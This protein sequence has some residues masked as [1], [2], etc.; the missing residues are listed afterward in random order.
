MNEM[1]GYEKYFLIVASA[2]IFAVGAIAAEKN[3]KYVAV[4]NAEE[5]TDEEIYLI[6]DKESGTAMS[7]KVNPT[8][9]SFKPA[10]MRGKI[11][12]ARVE[13][14]RFGTIYELT[15]S[16]GLMKCEKVNSTTYIWK[17]SNFDNG[18]GETSNDSKLTWDGSTLNASASG[19]R[20]YQQITKDGR[21]LLYSSNDTSYQ[22]RFY[23]SNASN[24][25]WHI[26]KKNSPSS[27]ETPSTTYLYKQ[28]EIGKPELPRLWIGD[29]EVCNGET[30]VIKNNCA[31]TIYVEDADKI[32]VNGEKVA[33]GNEATLPA[34]SGKYEVYGKNSEGESESFVYN[35]VYP[36]YI[37]EPVLNVADINSEDEYII[38]GMPG[39]N[40]GENIQGSYFLHYINE[41]P[42]AVVNGINDNRGF[43]SS[44]SCDISHIKFKPDGGNWKIY[45]KEAGYEKGLIETNTCNLDMSEDA[46][47][48]NINVIDGVL[49]IQARTYA[50]RYLRYANNT[51]KFY[52]STSALGKDYWPVY[53]Y[54]K[55]DANKIENISAIKSAPDADCYNVE[56]EFH[57]QL[58]SKNHLLLECYESKR[59]IMLNVDDA[60]SDIINSARGDVVSSII[61][62]ID[63]KNAD[64]LQGNLLGLGSSLRFEPI[65]EILSVALIRVY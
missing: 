25:F 55:L 19:T 24:Y 48:F 27:L 64:M 31:I 62:S 46:Y 52:F 42:G 49:M 2:I 17:W 30:K 34:R 1:K 57:V 12:G 3:H 47:A 43:L 51:N 16:V 36:E 32:I 35:L 13:R 4:K 18:N 58:I 6:F 11:P 8:E 10:V 50:T 38:R 53:L 41:K 22:L 33:S 45:F 21:F 20:F 29:G 40:A 28:V 63:D 60:F 9:L 65:D 37:Y 54:R 61:F 7:N 56:G 14:N 26:T 39:Q 44:S 5:I 15:D 23:L 59:P